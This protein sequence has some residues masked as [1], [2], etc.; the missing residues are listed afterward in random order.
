MARSR[1]TK[2]TRKYVQRFIVL[3]LLLVLACLGWLTWLWWQERDETGMVRYP[4]F[5]ISMPT[6][7]AIHGIDVSRYQEGIGWSSVSAMDIDGIRIG[8]AFIKATEGVSSAD[9]QF[10]RNWK[11]SKKAG[12]V[13]GAYHFF[14]PGK[15]GRLQA[16]HFIRTVPLEQGDLPPVVDIEGA[17]NVKPDLLRRELKAWLDITER[18]YGV[19]P[20]LYTYLNFY[21]RYLQGHFD[22]YPLWVAHYLQPEGPRITRTWAFWQHSEQGHVNGIRARVDFNV[23][24][25]DSTAFRALLVP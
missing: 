14:S 10:R 1:R 23:F 21:E 19:R 7:Y 22:D 18:Y 3:A 6:Q 20:I 17:A 16:E 12:I 24:S 4:E 11:G 9:P 5:G 2:Q 15:S 8:F 25:G 13:R